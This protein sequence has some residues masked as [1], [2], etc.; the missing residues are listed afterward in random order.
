MIDFNSA[1]LKLIELAQQDDEVELLWLYGS[2]AKETDHP[3]S[4]IDLAVVFKTW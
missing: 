3:K 2:Y 1:K 4:D